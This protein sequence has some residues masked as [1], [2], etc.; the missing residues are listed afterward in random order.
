MQKLLLFSCLSISYA[1]T[2][3]CPYAV[4]LL[5]S[6]GHCL[7][8][9]LTVSSFHAPAKIVW[10]KDGTVV[11]TD[12]AGTNFNPS[13]MTVLAPQNDGVTIAT[14]QPSFIFVDDSGYIYLGDYTGTKI[15]KWTPF[16]SQAV[17]V[18]GGNEQGSAQDQLF[19]PQGIFVDKQGNLYIADNRNNRVQKWAPG[20]TTGVTVAGGNGAGSGANQLYSPGPVYVDCGGNIYVADVLNNRVQKWAPGASSGIT[21]AGGNGSGPAANQIGILNS[22]WL[23]GSGNI[24]VL[25]IGNYRIARWAPG[26]ASGVTVAGGNGTGN[27]QDQIP[28]VES[29]YVDSS[30]NA[31]YV[32]NQGANG[33]NCVQEWPVG[34]TAAIM[35]AGGSHAGSAANEF[36]EPAGIAFDR[37]GNLYVSDLN[38]HRV[39]EFARDTIMRS[40]TP[41][42]TG[43]YWAVVTDF[44]GYSG[45]SDTITIIV[46]PAVP[47]S[48]QISATATRVDICQPV[49]FTAI[50]TNAGPAPFYQWQVSGV[51]VGTDTTVYSNDL[52]A[53]GDQVICILTTDVG[54]YP[55][56]DTSNVIT[57]AVD[58]QQ[59][60]TVTIADSPAVICQGLPE[61]FTATTINGSA[62][63][64]FQW[65]VNGDS[66]GDSSP[67]YSSDTLSS[68][69]VVYCLITS[70]A[71]CGL[72]KSN[73]IS[74]TV[75]PVPVITPGQVFNVPYGKSLQLD[76]VV[77]GNVVSYHW[78]PP[79]GL[80]DTAVRDPV[81]DPAATMEYNLQVVSAG[82]CKV[83]AEITVNVYTPVRLP[84][85]FTPNGDGRNDVFYVLGGPEGSV[86]K[87]FNI[88]DRWGQEVFR[89]HD[90]TPGDPAFGWD[91]RYGGKPAPAGVYVYEVVMSYP[92]G[93]MQRYQGTV[94][95]VR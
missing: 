55:A 63:T 46:P 82:G 65:L 71:S 86:I 52:F 27:K 83:S 93:G 12:T 64:A 95:L 81:A 54:C 21:V 47:P 79:V 26:A 49:S 91:G 4:T 78:S 36:N 50:A 68:G 84:N 80:S 5:S 43:R 23:D 89:V 92:G 1:C 67:V 88:Y 74:V 24:Y 22:I 85:A 7:G 17:T 18:A 73:S 41:V 58:A 90:G 8:A 14:F 28:A 20:A 39:Q 62:A 57:L 32:E 11:A 31:F 25:D 13:G 33:P 69:D 53:N 16:S 70:N 77:T 66:T 48:I 56:G 44:S 35:I 9:T 6:G 42:A 19:G 51:N 76:P 3:Q 87:G 10:Y 94:V 40:F 30:G 60:A 15:Q 45:Q 61:T 75:N 2:A 34:A 29:L 59:Y 37:N 38:N 72:S